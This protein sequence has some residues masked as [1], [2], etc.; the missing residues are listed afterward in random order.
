MYIIWYEL[1]PNANTSQT[2]SQTAWKRS[3]PTQNDANVC[4]HMKSMQSMPHSIKVQ[5]IIY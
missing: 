1:L 4:K 5:T 2:E 3:S